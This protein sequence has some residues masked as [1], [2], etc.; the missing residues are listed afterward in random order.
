M[1]VCIAVI[2]V[3]D[4]SEMI[5][6]ASDRM[7]TAGDIEFEPHQTKIYLLSEKVVAMTA[8]DA[9]AQITLFSQTQKDIAT[10]S[11]V[12]VKEIAEAWARHFTSYR[13]KQ[14]G[15]HFGPAWLDV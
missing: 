8:G 7:L 15:C 2:C 11:L 9:A 4:G 1:T 10:R 12:N 14:R 5:I 6:G 13:L 3:G